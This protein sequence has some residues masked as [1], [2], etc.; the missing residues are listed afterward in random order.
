MIKISLPQNFL[1]LKQNDQLL[2]FLFLF[3]LGLTWGSS[4]ILIK[5]GLEAFS[6]LQVAMLR[7]GISGIAFLPLAFRYIFKLSSA[8]KWKLVAVGLL[9]SGLPAIFFAF[10]QTRISS[11]MAG[12]LS[13]FTPL[14]TYF[15]GL[16][17]FGLLFNKRKFL[18]VLMGLIGAVLMI[19]LSSAGSENGDWFFG[20]L[21][22]AATICYALNSNIIKFYFQNYSPFLIATVSFSLTGVPVFFMLFLTDFT[23]V[24]SEH[25]QAW[26]SLGYLAL[27]A[28]FGTVIA[29]VIFFR[30][31]QITDAVFASSVS[32]LVPL[33]A[34][35]WGVLDGEL[36]HWYHFAGMLLILGGIYFSRKKVR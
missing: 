20:F 33:F 4:Y 1:Y 18:G 5:K 35:F 7:F 12:I 24:L 10:A 3:L 9:G 23:T 17:I 8:E 11:S 19:A 21:V 32:Y 13:S 31:V 14:A 2:G 36:L 29:S 6:P 34:L 28:I 25:P 27:L 15:F 16:L 22:I 30:L 26:A